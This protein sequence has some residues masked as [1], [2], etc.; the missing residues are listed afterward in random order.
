MLKDLGIQLETYVASEID[1]DAIKVRPC[2]CCIALCVWVWVGAR[3]L[4]HARERSM[5]DKCLCVGVQL[6]MHE[7]GTLP[8]HE[9]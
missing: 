1:E 9:V 4:I 7:R 3:P 8:Y 5:T 6:C 2:Y